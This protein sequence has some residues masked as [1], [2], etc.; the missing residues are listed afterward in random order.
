MDPEAERALLYGK[1]EELSLLGD[2]HD[3]EIGSLLS[4]MQDLLGHGGEDET[5]PAKESW[6][7]GS[8]SFSERFVKVYK[9]DMEEG[10]S[11]EFK[12]RPGK[13]GGAVDLGLTVWDGA[14]VL[15]KY[16]ELNVDLVRGRGCVELGAGTGVVGVVAAALGAHVTL[17]DMEEVLPLTRI[18]VDLN[19]DKLA[20]VVV[21]VEPFLWGVQGP[22]CDVVLGADLVSYLY[23]GEAL[24]ETLRLYP[25]STQ[26][27]ISWE[28]HDER[29]PTR[30]LE[31]A[32]RFFDVEMIPHERMHS[33]YQ[34]PSLFIASMFPKRT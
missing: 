13:D 25:E 3:D 9:Y 5:A 15:A 20:N 1:I 10:Q 12:Q 26:I 23:S 14:I 2:G 32:H 16:L 31:L 4:R 8:L 6:H 19:R 29:A 30:F 27:L 7:R 28:Q 11:F 21:R 17:T 18:N 33:R 24:I 34:K 22:P